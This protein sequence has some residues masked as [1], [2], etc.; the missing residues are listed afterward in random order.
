MRSFRL[1]TI[2]VLT[3]LCAWFAFVLT[4]YTRRRLRM[5]SIAKTLLMDYRTFSILPGPLNPTTA[6][7]GEERL[8]VVGESS[9][10]FLV[11]SIVRNPTCSDSRSEWR[12]D[13]CFRP[14]LNP[15]YPRTAI[16]MPFDHFPNQLDLQRFRT[17]ALK[18]PWVRWDRPEG[19]DPSFD[20]FESLA[21]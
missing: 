12:V 19:T 1:P 6:I 20:S 8:L 17:E 4:Q 9:D 7:D 21:E 3:L 16:W 15:G 5:R 2:V 11:C 14:D 18:Q 10:D 13:H